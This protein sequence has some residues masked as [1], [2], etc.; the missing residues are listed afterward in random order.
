VE[1][2]IVIQI[3]PEM[4]SSIAFMRTLQS[5]TLSYVIQAM[6]GS[7]LTNN[8]RRSKIFSDK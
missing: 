6:L 4:V 2:G 3:Q 1:S 8:G 5:S 7:L